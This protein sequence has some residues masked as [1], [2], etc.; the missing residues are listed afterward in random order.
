MFAVDLRLMTENVKSSLCIAQKQQPCPPP[1]FLHANISLAEE[2]LAL[3][4]CPYSS[5]CSCYKIGEI[6]AWR[7]TPTKVCLLV[8]SLMF[9]TIRKVLRFFL[10]ASILHRDEVFTFQH[11]PFCIHFSSKDFN[12]HKF[13]DVSFRMNIRKTQTP[14]PFG[15]LFYASHPLTFHPQHLLTALSTKNIAYS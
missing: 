14:V 3:T 7:K 6:F 15:R 5:L 13:C 12:V 4:F 2:K 1:L 11:S 10:R 9:W 8:N